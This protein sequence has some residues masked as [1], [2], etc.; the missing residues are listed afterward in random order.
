MLRRHEEIARGLEVSMSSIR[1]GSAH[2]SK[3]PLSPEEREHRRSSQPQL[4]VPPVGRDFADMCAQ[5][6]GDG[7]HANV[8][9]LR[10]ASS[11]YDGASVDVAGTELLNF[12]S[13]SYLGLEVRPEVKEG[14]IQAVRQYGTQFPFAKP[15][16]ECA[17][18]RELE[19]TLEAMTDGKVLIASSATLAHLAAMPALMSPRDAI[20]VDRLAHASLYTAASL[21]KHVQ[22]EVLAHNQMDYLAARIADLSRTHERVW[23][24]LDGVYSMSGDFAPIATLRT[25]MEEFP[26][27]HLY[28]D[29]AHCT[30]WMGKHGRGFTL[31][32]IGARDRVIVT[33]SL[34]KAFSAAGGAL[35]VP[36]EEFRRRIRFAGA[37][38]MFSGPIQ[39]P[40]LGAAVASAK[41]HLTPQFET[42]QRNLHERIRR[43]HELAAIH[44]VALTTSD[45]T[46][47][48][49]IPCGQE[50]SM[51]S[52]FHA[53]CKQGFYIA[54]AVF[55][56]VPRNRAGL[57]LTASLHN[58]PA[59]TERL[60]AVLA[61]ELRKIPAIVEFQNE[62]RH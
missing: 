16:L 37:A 28:A 13:C 47:I 30:S 23:Y 55:P 14:A 10:S 36:N 60:M 21:L 52:L 6:I 59:D 29:D 33:L 58:S 39:P 4:R 22:Q 25:L 50:Q 49:F 8:L 57:R 26:K 17:L 19:T 42:L 9:L 44:E 46:P 7:A 54:P 34:N 56:A 51:F 62:F 45:R 61:S 35:V 12:G 41:I 40:M 32:E 11:G 2:S 5:S 43:I 53:M 1:A 3:H 38:M 24:V 18:Y 15:Q 20:I 31:Q 48:V 27:L